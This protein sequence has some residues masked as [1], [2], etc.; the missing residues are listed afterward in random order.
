MFD[1]LQLEKPLCHWD[2]LLYSGPP[3]KGD[4][5]RNGV[6]IMLTKKAN[7]NERNLRARFQSKFQR[8]SIIQCFAPINA[9]DQEAKEEFYEQ[10]QS[11][12]ERMPNRDIMI[13][14]GDFNA[15]VGNDKST[16][17]IIMGKEGI[18]TMNKNGELFIDFCEQHDLVIAGMVFP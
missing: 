11:V 18:G 6:D 3:N 13:V 16:R 2:V 10:L 9:A 15:K 5:H 7:R 8:V 14:L 17:E 4:D 1:G 12:L